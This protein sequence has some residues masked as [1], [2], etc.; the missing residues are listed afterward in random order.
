MDSRTRQDALV[1]LLRTRGESTAQELALHFTVSTRTIPRDIS[2]LRAHAIPVEAEFGRGGGIR[3]QSN[4]AIPPVR[5]EPAELLGLILAV[6]LARQASILPFS[7][8][9]QAA[10]GK[11]VAALPNERARH[12]RRLCRRVL[13]GPPASQALTDR[14]GSVPKNVI[15]LFEQAFSEQRIMTF[16]Y[17]DRL[18]AQTRREVEP[19]GLLPVFVPYECYANRS[20]T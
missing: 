4:W 1:G 14:R 5:F 2:A 17:V 11:A 6:S 13:V 3:L 16:S 15:D 8:C 10:L 7:D 9:A 20:L 19:Q 12:I 18:G